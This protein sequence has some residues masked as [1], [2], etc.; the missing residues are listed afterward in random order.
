MPKVTSTTLNYSSEITW[1]CMSHQPT[2]D[3]FVYTRLY[4]HNHNKTLNDRPSLKK[5]DHVELIKFGIIG[6]NSRWKDAHMQW[7]TRH[8]TVHEGR[9]QVGLNNT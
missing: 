9:Q 2:K 1:H 7:V 8:V 3:L 5:E 6:S 4:N